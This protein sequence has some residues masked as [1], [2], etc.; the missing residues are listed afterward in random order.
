MIL[1][2]LKSISGCCKAII[3][4]GMI[5]EKSS[6]ALNTHPYLRHETLEGLLLLHFIACWLAHHLLALVKLG[7]AEHGDM[8]KVGH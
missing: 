6:C 8:V 5:S 3:G 7:I 4:R 2:L 1:A